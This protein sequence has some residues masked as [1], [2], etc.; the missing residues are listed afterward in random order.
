MSTRQQPISEYADD[1]MGSGP[2]DRSRALA[3][4]S[5]QSPQQRMTER[6]QRMNEPCTCPSCGSTW[7]REE[8]FNQYRKETY[9][10]RA[11]GDLEVISEMPQTLRVCLCGRPLSPNIGGAGHGGATPSEQMTSFKLS[12]KFALNRLDGLGA[13]PA[14][15]V[16]TMLDAALKQGNFAAEFDKLGERVEELGNLV[17]S[18]TKPDAPAQ[19]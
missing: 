19:V 17:D 12:L 13:D 16:R 7:F 9:S 18:L 14:P 5:R 3:S 10:S 15:V 2:Q 1:F 11:G 8:T 4:M 6:E